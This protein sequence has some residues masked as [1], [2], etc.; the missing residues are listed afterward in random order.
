MEI[1]TIRQQYT[2]AYHLLRCIMH[3]YDEPGSAAAL[4]KEFSDLYWSNP[5]AGSAAAASYQDRHT[6]VKLW[7]DQ[8]HADFW[9]VSNAIHWRNIC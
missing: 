5:V 7:R 3:E 8:M 2:Q 1:T 6:R 9:I 4:Q